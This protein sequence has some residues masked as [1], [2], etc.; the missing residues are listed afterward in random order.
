MAYPLSAERVWPGAHEQA[1]QVEK[2]EEL[3]EKRKERG[4]GEAE[5]SVPREGDKQQLEWERG[6][7]GE[8][9][10]YARV[11][12]LEEKKPR[13]VVHGDWSDRIGSQQSLLWPEC[14]S[15][16][17]RQDRKEETTE[18]KCIAAIETAREMKRRGK[19]ETALMM[20]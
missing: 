1:R 18:T 19:S 17:Q 5:G 11:P 13:S 14:A 20:A 10:E 12:Q 2:E 9:E 4:G 7:G 8:G 15:I 3:G 6:G 16:R